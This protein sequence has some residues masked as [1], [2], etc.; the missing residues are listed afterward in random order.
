MTKGTVVR[1]VAGSPAGTVGALVNRALV[2]IMPKAMAGVACLMVARVSGWE[3]D[4]R[5]TSSPPRLYALKDA[6][7][8]RYQRG[9]RG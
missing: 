8:V 4:L 3:R 9:G 7:F 6:F 2:P 1:V 5:V